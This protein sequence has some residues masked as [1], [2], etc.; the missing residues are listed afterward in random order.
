MHHSLL[1]LHLR[2]LLRVVLHVL[3]LLNGL[4]C[5]RRHDRPLRDHVATRWSQLLL[6]GRLLGWLQLILR[7]W[8]L[9]L[10]QSLQLSGW[11]T[12]LLLLLLWL[13]LLLLLLLSLL[14]LLL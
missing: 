6:L 4:T 1:L 3:L 10:Q 2:H 14:L 12:H 11:P 9:L 13:L 7:H 5:P 8:G